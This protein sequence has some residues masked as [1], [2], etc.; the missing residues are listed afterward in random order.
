[1]LRGSSSGASARCQHLSTTSREKQQQNWRYKLCKAPIVLALQGMRCGSNS[2][3][4]PGATQ[5]FSCALAGVMQPSPGAMARATQA[6]IA[7]LAWARRKGFHT[8]KIDLLLQLGK[9]AS[10]PKSNPQRNKK[11]INLLL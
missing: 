1:M 10:N 8:A 11:S 5:P 4:R 3:A 9:G 2:G 7:E 6:N